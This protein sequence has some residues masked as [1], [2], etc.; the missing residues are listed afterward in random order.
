MSHFFKLLSGLSWWYQLHNVSGYLQPRLSRNYLFHTT[1]T[2][3]MLYNTV[4]ALVSVPSVCLCRPFL[5][6]PVLSVRRTVFSG[7]WA[8]VSTFSALALCPVNKVENREAEDFT[9]F[10]DK[11]SFETQNGLSFGSGLL[12]YCGTF[13]IVTSR[14]LWT[15]VGAC[16]EPLWWHGSNIGY[17]YHNSCCFMLEHDVIRLSSVF[18]VG[19]SWRSLNIAVLFL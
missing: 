13:V 4:A 10:A 7:H 16:V 2:S 3:V 17:T 6:R 1:L 15:Y 12:Q 9:L 11:T 5:L 14:L 8:C 19:T 18:F